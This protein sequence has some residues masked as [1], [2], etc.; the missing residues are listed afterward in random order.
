[1][2]TPARITSQIFKSSHQRLSAEQSRLGWQGWQKPQALSQDRPK[3][4]LRK[5]TLGNPG[6][7]VLA[8][9]EPNVAAELEK[10]LHKGQDGYYLSQPVNMLTRDRSKNRFLS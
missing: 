7:A 10:Q 2:H 4:R 8:S 9:L 6:Y 5:V 1:M 3:T